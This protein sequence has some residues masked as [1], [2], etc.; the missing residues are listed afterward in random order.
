[1]RRRCGS[2]EGFSLIEVMFAAFLA[3]FMLTATF[4]LVV[5]SAKQG[6]SAN[7]MS[8]ATNLGNLLIEQAR[9]MTYLDVGTVGG[10][11]PEISGTLAS[12]ETTSYQGVEFTITRS[13]TWVDDPVNNTTSTVNATDYKHVTIGVTWATGSMS[14]ETYVR[15][16]SNEQGGIPTVVYDNTVVPAANSVIF[17][18]TGQHQACK[19][20]GNSNSPSETAGLVWL[21]A[22]ANT[23]GTA[24]MLTRLQFW[25]SGANGA[26]MPL[27]NDY[28]TPLPSPAYWSLAV[29]SFTTSG[30]P[31]YPVDSKSM[32]DSSTPVWRD[33]VRTVK[34]Q[35]WSANGS[36][37]Y[38]TRDLLVDNYAPSWGTSNTVTLTTPTANQD[39][40]YSRLLMQWTPPYD[41]T[42][43]CRH[44]NVRIATVT[45]GGGNSNLDSFPTEPNRTALDPSGSYMLGTG[46][47]TGLIFAP[48]TLYD[49]HLHIFGPRGIC[50]PSSGF[51]RNNIDSTRPRAWTAPR[52][53]GT[54]VK[55]GNNSDVTLLYSVPNPAVAVTYY[56]YE[57]SS[58]TPGTNIPTLVASTAASSYTTNS[59]NPPMYFQ[60]EARLA[61]IP[62]GG[63]DVT[64]MRSNVVYLTGA[65]TGPLMIP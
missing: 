36:T 46:A 21:K 2:E 39:R 35:V 9:S 49:V 47:P 15:D 18:P 31:G 52:L 59:V 24:G 26:Q 57:S 22:S 4:G 38:R 58:W 11:S 63:P 5:S 37:D 45:A 27:L 56:I 1:V 23:T 44:Y 55:I 16:R 53:T 65:A 34:V 19:W 25:I 40:Y 17:N 13:V 3:F 51:D 30:T 32:D 60:V 29:A 28:A 33:G 20:S 50:G 54:G 12:S 48:L 8:I 43:V 7:V 41:G 10:V 62:S 6:R 61:A 42:D 64:Y 14:F